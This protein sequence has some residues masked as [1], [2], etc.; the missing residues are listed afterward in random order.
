MLAKISCMLN[1]NIQA[2]ISGIESNLKFNRDIITVTILRI[3]FV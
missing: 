2:L 1:I 3:N